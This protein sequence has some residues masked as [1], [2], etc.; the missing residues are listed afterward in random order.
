MNN[1]LKRSFGITVLKMLAADSSLK[2]EHAERDARE[3]ARK[4]L[5]T[6]DI[7]EKARADLLEQVGELF[8]NAAEHHALCLIALTAALQ[9]KDRDEE[10]VARLQ[11]AHKAAMSYLNRPQR[12]AA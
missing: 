4:R 8:F 6:S 5:Q 2:L 10:R 3:D 11:L 1:G 7:P 9:H 12:I